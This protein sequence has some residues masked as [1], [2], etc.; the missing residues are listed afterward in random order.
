MN[1]LGL[2]RLD[3]TPFSPWTEHR[4]GATYA[5]E[6]GGP[7]LERVLKLCRD[8]QGESYPRGCGKR[9]EGWVFAPGQR[10]L[11]GIP[12]AIRRQ[13]TEDGAVLGLCDHC[14]DRHEQKVE[15]V[16]TTENELALEPPMRTRE[17]YD[18]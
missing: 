9:Y 12:L 16:K 8:A 4:L 18:E 6:A 13:L 17:G 1:P 14:I 15:P 11:P 7:K 5:D 2:T 3:W 10:M